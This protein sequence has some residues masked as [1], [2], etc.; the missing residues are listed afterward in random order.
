MNKKTEEREKQT[1]EIDKE[2]KNPK[3]Q[4]KKENEIL[5]NFL[6]ILGIVVLFFIGIYV[7][8]KTL[9]GFEYQG[10]KWDTVKAGDITFYHTEFP[11][12]DQE[13]VQIA[14]HN[15]YFR[16]DPRQVEKDVE[17]EGEFNARYC[18]EYN[19]DQRQNKAGQCPDFNPVNA[20]LR[21]YDQ[22]LPDQFFIQFGVL[23]KPLLVLDPDCFYF[24]KFHSLPVLFLPYSS[25]VLLFSK[26]GFRHLILKYL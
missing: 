12:Y 6:I 17:F 2:E 14:N 11:V 22:Q 15:V 13:G 26:F 19:A 3:S 20:L 1:P 9:K 7:G 18:D 21:I 8:S 23:H 24:L 25:I 4:V 10:L 5:R 16:N